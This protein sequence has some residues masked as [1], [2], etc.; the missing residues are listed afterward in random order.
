MTRLV[1]IHVADCEVAEV[2]GCPTLI[3][4]HLY[5]DVRSEGQSR[6]LRSGSALVDGHVDV[7]GLAGQLE[8][9]WLGLQL[10]DRPFSRAMLEVRYPERDQEELD[11]FEEVPFSHVSRGDVCRQLSCLYAPSFQGTEDALDCDG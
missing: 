3:F 2:L 11:D 4:S 8:L 10:L 7:E 5:T 1:L 6:H 9:L